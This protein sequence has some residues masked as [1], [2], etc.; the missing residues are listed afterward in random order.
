LRQGTERNLSK[1][2]QETLTLA[3]AG[4]ITAAIVIILLQRVKGLQLPLNLTVT[5]FY[6][7]FVL[8]LFSYK[9]GDWLYIQLFGK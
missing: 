9:I 8:G 3:A 4:G 7:G 6:G 5:D 1:V 2:I